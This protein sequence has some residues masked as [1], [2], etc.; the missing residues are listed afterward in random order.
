MNWAAP[1]CGIK[2]QQGE[3]VKNIF[4]KIITNPLLFIIT[5][6]YHKTKFILGFIYTNHNFLL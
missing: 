6:L 1:P 4:Y 2:L 5:L 3:N